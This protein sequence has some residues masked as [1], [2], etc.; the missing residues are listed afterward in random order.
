MQEALVDDDV[1]GSGTAVLDVSLLALVNDPVL[2]EKWIAG[3]LGR[4]VSAA[5]AKERTMRKHVDGEDASI[6]IAAAL[7]FTADAFLST[8]DQ[9]TS[10]RKKTILPRLHLI[11]EALRD[12]GRSNI[13]S[14]CQAHRVVLLGAHLRRSR[15]LMR[16]Q[17]SLD[18][19]MV[20]WILNFRDLCLR[21][22]KLWLRRVSMSQR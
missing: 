5:C 14:L 9:A 12:A 10:T 13:R 7:S 6:T 17:T 18:V 19:A 21:D 8:A 15:K 1:L 2:P 3:S 4:D 20:Y 22:E 11:V 16:C